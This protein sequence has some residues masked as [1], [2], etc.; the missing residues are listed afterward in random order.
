VSPRLPASPPPFCTCSSYA[1]VGGAL[2]AL[3]DHYGLLPRIARL[4]AAA[5]QRATSPSHAAASAERALAQ[6]T[7]HALLGLRDTLQAAADG[8]DPALN[9]PTTPP[10]GPSAAAIGVAATSTSPFAQ[11]ASQPR[12]LGQ[13]SGHVARGGSIIPEAPSSPTSSAIDV[14]TYPGP[15]FGIVHGD[16]H[17]GNIM[18]DSRS[19]A[20]LIDYGEVRRSPPSP[21]RLTRTRP[22][23]LTHDG[24]VREE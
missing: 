1:H 5:E 23:G 19:Y 18:V 21:E 10:S 12:P 3:A 7:R 22:R 2:H 16:L 9:R 4:L 15:W 24:E 14:A 13:P 11:R 6:P 8:I 20:W 17:G